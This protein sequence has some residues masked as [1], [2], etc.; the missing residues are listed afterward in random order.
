MP[1]KN[2]INLIQF[3]YNKRII[4]NI[5]FVCRSSV[6]TIINILLCYPTTVLY[7]NIL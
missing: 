2:T 3:N 7:M 5:L 1:S 6:G 4:D